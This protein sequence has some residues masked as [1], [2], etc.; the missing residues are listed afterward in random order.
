MTT[1][2]TAPAPQRQL[3]ADVPHEAGEIVAHFVGRM[4]PTGMTVQE[5]ALLFTALDC[6]RRAVEPAA[7]SPASPPNK[8]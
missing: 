1:P 6:V 8:R 4:T 2:D 7:A 5:V 3:R